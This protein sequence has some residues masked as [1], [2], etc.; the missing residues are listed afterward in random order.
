[1]EYSDLIKLESNFAKMEQVRT[2]ISKSVLEELKDRI[3]IGYDRLSVILGTS[4]GRLRRKKSDEKFNG[5]ISEKIL[6]L[7]DV[8]EFGYSVFEDQ[9]NLERWMQTEN[10]ALSNKR[11]IDLLDTSFGMIEVKNLLGR[12]AHGVY[13]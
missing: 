7:S 13:S 9:A 5:P 6:A 1:M 8:Y 10:R 11:P 2:G 12:I 3:N 4:S